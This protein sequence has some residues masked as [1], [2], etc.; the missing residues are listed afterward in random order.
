M[1]DYVTVLQFCLKVQAHVCDT[2]VHVLMCHTQLDFSILCEQNILSFNVSVNHMMGVKMGKALEDKH[3]QIIN[4][5]S[6]DH[7]KY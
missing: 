3:M 6:D 1:F 2:A 5:E 4:T 7:Y